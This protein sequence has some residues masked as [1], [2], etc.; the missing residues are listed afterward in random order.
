[1]TLAS[2]LVTR[3]RANI[4]ESTEKDRTDPQILQWLDDSQYDY[5][6]KVPMQ[7]FP[8][9]HTSVAFSGST[10][11]IPSDYMFF[12]GLTVNHT[13]SG[14]FTEICDAFMLSPGETYL[15]QNYP[16]NIGAW[17]QIANG[18]LK[19]GPNV[20][21]GTLSYVKKPAAIT[22]STVTFGLGIEHEFPLVCKASSLALLKLNDADAAAFNQLYDD[23]VE[24]R[25]SRGESDDIER[26]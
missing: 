9:L 23:N 13:I 18:Q 16:G 21:S 7:H 6:H 20:F 10:C 17:G 2:A 4:N 22:A 12:L 19:A 5:L 24:A 15:I 8:E 1:M 26:A 3:V 25:K 14:T 11:A